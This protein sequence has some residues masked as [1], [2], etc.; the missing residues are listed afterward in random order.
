MRAAGGN[1]TEGVKFDDWLRCC[2]RNIKTRRRRHRQRRVG[3]YAMERSRKIFLE[4]SFASHKVTTA[5]NKYADWKGL[6]SV[7]RSHFQLE[8]D[9]Q[10]ISVAS[11][12]LADNLGK[13]SL[14]DNAALD[15][16]LQDWL[17][18]DEP[19]VCLETL[20]RMERLL[21]PEGKTSSLK[22]IFSRRRG[23]SC[24][25]STQDKIKEAVDLFGSRKA[26]FHFLVT[27]D[28]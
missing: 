17:S 28:W 27:T 3:W 19:G 13:A 2:N 23:T 11:D 15:I 18:G 4:I 16:R 5:A 9:M 21:Q 10:R 26:C 12:T 6:P 25:V 20:S 1:G 8:A 24:A 22:T 14:P 7:S